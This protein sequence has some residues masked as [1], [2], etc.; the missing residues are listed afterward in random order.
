MFFKNFFHAMNNNLRSIYQKRS[1]EIVKRITAMTNCGVI[2]DDGE[3]TVKDGDH[4]IELVNGLGRH[5]ILL[6]H[7]EFLNDRDLFELSFIPRL[8]QFLKSLKNIS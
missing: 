3:L 1:I 7:D 5:K 6:T 8:N 2:L 4:L